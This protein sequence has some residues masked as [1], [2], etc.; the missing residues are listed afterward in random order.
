MDV[1]SDTL[2]V[3]RLSGAVFL[4][5]KLTSPW[6]VESATPGELAEYLRLPS[7]C[8]AVFHILAQGVCWISV[9]DSSPIL[10]R[11]GDAILI[12][13][14]APH[15]IGSGQSQSVSPV[16]I[17]SI[18]PPLLPG[19]IAEVDGTGMGE[20]TRLV[21]GYLHCDQR[22]NPLIGALPDGMVIH[23]CDDG[24]GAGISGEGAAATSTVLPIQAGDWLETTLRHTVEEAL[25]EHPGN[26]DMLA[27]LSEILF[28]EVVRRYMLRLP[29][30]HHG[31]LAGVRDPIVGHALRLLHARPEY[32]WTVENLADAVAVSRSTLAQRFTMLIGETPMRYLAVWRIQR[33]KYL[34]KHTSLNL[35]EVSERVGYESNAAFNRAFKR[36]VGQPP[37]AWRLS[38]DGQ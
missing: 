28:V 16:P 27:R 21:C 6:A 14:S 25:G 19:G 1:L 5:A 38:G 17:R 9:S 10:L 22:F 18:L 12:P 13:R 7:D 30:T 2:R 11:A 3:V 32:A 31:W 35:V 15:I 29:A 24:Q 8:I 37:A 20:M 33:A 26:S 36:H 4:K 34:L 23:L